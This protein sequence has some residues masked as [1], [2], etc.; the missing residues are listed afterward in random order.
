MDTTT[1]TQAAESASYSVD[2]VKWAID[3]ICN[4]SRLDEYRRFREYHNGKQDLKFAT[5]K[6][7]AAFGA[8]FKAFSYNRCRAVVAAHTDRLYVESFDAGENESIVDK[9]EEIW[10]LNQM[11]KV[12]LEVHR[13]SCM[14]GA[15]YLYVW[16]DPD[17]ELPVVM[18]PQDP[19]TIAVRYK[20]DNPVKLEMAAKI[21]IQRDKRMRCTLYYEDEI[22]RLVTKE[23]MKTGSTPRVDWFE[24][25]LEDGEWSV[26]NPYGRVPIFPFFNHGEVGDM[27]G[28]SELTDVIPL[29]NAINKTLT[30]ELITEEFM[31]YPQRVI[32]GAETGENPYTDQSND[33]R[34]VDQTIKAFAAGA[35]RIMTISD[36]NAK[37]EE[38][39]AADL[40]QFTD[41]ADFWDTAISRTS[42]VPV[43]YLKL[44]GEFP[45][46]R[47]LRTA[48]APFIAKLEAQQR[49]FKNS[50]QEAMRFAL[51]IAGNKVEGRFSV[52]WRTAAP[53]AREDEMDLVLQMVAVG[54]P[55]EIALV[56]I[57][58]STAKVEEVTQLIE[59]QKEEAMKE[60]MALGGGAPTG[61]PNSDRKSPGTPNG[62]TNVQQR[63]SKANETRQ[64]RRGNMRIVS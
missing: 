53:M 14:T 58:W 50:W 47:A 11:D 40:K 38:F 18:W 52:K 35:L 30:D 63:A 16:E 44:T 57:G 5:E 31:A 60:M 1:V 61:G 4:A 33:Q 7:N 43:H 22:V 48:E 56:D 39:S 10:G 2:D 24:P 27:Y 46:G 64:A 49:D 28:T 26:D 13:T 59:K 36:P 21:W 41:M 45:S 15:S 3:H 25:Y 6:F 55:L 54:I 37:I 19:S 51:L 12:Q 34:S 32:L 23:P 17:G 8:L 42:R 9:A 29:Q 62:D 20:E